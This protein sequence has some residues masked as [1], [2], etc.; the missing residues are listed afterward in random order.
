MF[1]SL[2]DIK[3]ICTDCDDTIIP[4]GRRDLNPEYFT[5]IEKLIEKGVK[6]VVASGRQKPSIKKTFTP[7]VDKL[8]YLAD[9]GTD[10]TAPDYVDSLAF[11]PDDYQE[12]VA[13]LKSLGDEYHI[14]VC[15]PD[16]SYIQYSSEPF[17]HRMVDS[18]GY[19][20]E[21]VEDVAKVPG[22]CKI[23]LFRFDGIED[24]VTDLLTKRWGQRLA[25]CLAGELFYD[26]MPKGCNK[27]KGLALLQEHYHISPE[28]TAAF[29]NAPNDIEML[30]QA[31]Y[32]YAVAN[33]SE[34]LKAA[35][36]FEIG[37]MKDHAVLKVLEE[38][39][40]SI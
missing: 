13:H 40:R 20:A 14:M 16:C 33:A 31:K 12:L 15:K 6:V 32:S 35:A 2:H 30:R 25:A 34:D 1:G 7:V 19:T 38:I 37:H 17:F 23:S 4:E 21:M 5:M 8:I 29:G 27:G 24:E 28:E 22:V 10:I 11:A 18:Y 36:A 3:M 9:N 39:Y 26:F